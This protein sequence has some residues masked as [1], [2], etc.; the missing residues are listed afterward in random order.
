MLGRVVAPCR[1][2][3]RL[4]EGAKILQVEAESRGEVDRA[5]LE[6]LS[7]RGEAIV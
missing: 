3:R 4:A 7:R 1:R 2:A 5:H 6:V